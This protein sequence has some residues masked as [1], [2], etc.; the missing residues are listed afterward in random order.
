MSTKIAMLTKQD[1]PTLIQIS[2]IWADVMRMGIEAENNQTDA[3]WWLGHQKEIAFAFK[4]LSGLGLANQGG[5]TKDG[6]VVWNPS[7]PM[8]RLHRHGWQYYRYRNARDKRLQADL[9]FQ[10]DLLDELE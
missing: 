3:E 7:N 4:V 2:G 5:Q 9:A 10:Y 6:K 1:G 8:K